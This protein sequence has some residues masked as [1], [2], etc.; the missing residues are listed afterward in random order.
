[1]IEIVL[2]SVSG[3]YELEP[4]AVTSY[5]PGIEAIDPLGGLPAQIDHTRGWT[6]P[7]TNDD[8]AS[9]DQVGFALRMLY[10]IHSIIF[11]TMT[12]C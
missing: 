5:T 12:L 6:M 10:Y 1:M 7:F 11:K 3:Y 8:G 4:V 2:D 9:N